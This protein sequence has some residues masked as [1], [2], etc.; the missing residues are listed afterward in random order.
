MTAI[1]YALLIV[2]G[3]SLAAGLLLAVSSHFM[4]VEVDE[5]VACLRACLPGVNCGACGYNGC[6]S[7]AKALANDPSVQTNLCIP[8]GDK[9][10]AAI[11]EILGTEAQDVKEMVAFVACN[12]TCGAVDKKYDYRGQAS[13]RTANMSYSGDRYC[14][15]ACLGYGDCALVCPENAISVDTG[16]ARVHPKK[17]ICC[18]ICVRTCPNHIIELLPDTARVAVECSS[19]NKGAITKRF[20][21]NGCIGCKK[22]E[23][24]C[25]Y[26]AI[27][28]TD[29]LAHVDQSLCKGCGECAKVCPVGCIHEGDFICGAH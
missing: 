11:A 20:C 24:T 4:H 26:G 18:V 23:K 1:L 16:V 15:F 9:T 14:T 3:V 7:Y 29:N 17:C 28:V 5:T 2:G 6:D 27:T 25:Q 12:G 21:D 19:H 10:A 22:C 8:G 13:C